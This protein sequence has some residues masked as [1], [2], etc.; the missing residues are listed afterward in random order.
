MRPHLAQPAEGIQPRSRPFTSRRAAGTDP[1]AASLIQQNR[2]G[3]NDMPIFFYLP[4]IIATGMLSV[5][6]ETMR[7][8]AKQK[9]RATKN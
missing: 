4:L 3:I 7:E 6:A 9:V 8:P 1:P 2:R 5:A